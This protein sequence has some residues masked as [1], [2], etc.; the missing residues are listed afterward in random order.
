MSSELRCCTRCGTWKPALEFALC[1]GKPRARCRPCHTADAVRW[2]EQNPERHK[3]KQMD[4]HRKNVVKTH[5]GPPLPEH[6]RLQRDRA[7]RKRWSDAN[8]DKM[9]AC[10]KAWT[11]ENAHIGMER[12]RRR[13][14]AKLQATPPW[15][16][17]QAMQEFYRAARELTKAT[18]TPHEVDH[19]VPL[20]SPVVCGLHCEANLQVLPR[21]ANRS[22][23]NRLIECAGESSQEQAQEAPKAPHAPHA[24]L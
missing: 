21:R 18:G 19:I 3:Q 24:R 17:K 5:Y 6:I 13:Q 9:N 15:A 8:P 1:R 7:R 4:W 23:S 10:R 11:V 12:V 2:Q 22:K 20:I 16:S 14:A